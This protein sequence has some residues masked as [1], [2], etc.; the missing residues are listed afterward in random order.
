VGR[1]SFFTITWLILVSGAL[2]LFN[3]MSSSNYAISCGKKI[4]PVLVVTQ[5]S[6][7]D[8]GILQSSDHEIPLAMCLLKGIS[9][10]WTWCSTGLLLCN[11]MSSSNYAISCGKEIQHVLVVTKCSKYG[12]GIL[13][14]SDHEIPLAICLLKGISCVW[15][16]CSTGLLFWQIICDVG[17]TSHIFSCGASWAEVKTPE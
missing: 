17:S 1:G 6:K 15:T 14:S 5:C 9:C 12:E 13:Q 7:Y 10:V 4:Q 8:E 11:R 2:L 3:R 16:W